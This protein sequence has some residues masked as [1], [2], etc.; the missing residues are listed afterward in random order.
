MHG[1][2]RCFRYPSNSSRTARSRPGLTARGGKPRTSHTTTNSP[3]GARAMPASH[4]R[5]TTFMRPASGPLP[6]SHDCMKTYQGLGLLCLRRQSGRPVVGRIAGPYRHRRSV[7][8]AVGRTRAGHV[9]ACRIADGV[10]S[11]GA[12][13]CA[14]GL[15]S[16]ASVGLALWCRIASDARPRR[17]R[18]YRA[19]RGHLHHSVH[20]HPPHWVN[21]SFHCCTGG[22]APVQVGGWRASRAGSGR[23]TVGPAWAGPRTNHSVTPPS[24]APRL[25]RP[26]DCSPRHAVPAIA[27]GAR[28]YGPSHSPWHR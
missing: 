19:V 4:D 27:G 14:P 5:M 28:P 11:W 10:N 6:A 16:A 18:G 1:A 23:P 24:V 2:A 8:R 26:L 12:A 7:E 9:H 13:L 17:S 20:H 21:S 15:A 3:T 22:P 25:T